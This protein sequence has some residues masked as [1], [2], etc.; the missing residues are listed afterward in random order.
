VVH[1]GQFS[2]GSRSDRQLWQ[3]GRAVSTF[4]FLVGAAALMLRKVF[5][6]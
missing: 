6:R 2:F 3:V 5:R 1:L 4:G